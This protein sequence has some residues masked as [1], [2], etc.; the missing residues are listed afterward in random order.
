M[1]LTKHHGLGNDF[2][3]AVDQ[4]ALGDPA[5]SARRWCHR[6]TG[7]GADGLILA[8]TSPD[9]PAVMTLYN[10]D[11][12]RAEI[13]GN[14]LRCLVQALARR[15]G[16]AHWEGTV[17]TDAGLRRAWLEPTDRSDR[18]LVRVEMG[19]VVV[20]GRFGPSDVP[21]PL[22]ADHAMTVDVGNP[23]LVL[24]VADPEA[25]ALD[26]VGPALEQLVPGGVNVHFVM[27]TSDGA[28]LATHWERGAGVTQ[29]CGSGA[30][31]SAHA[32]HHWGAVGRDVTVLMPGGRARVILGS[33]ALLEG[34]A[35]FVAT[36]EV[37]GDS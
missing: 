4:I 31:A 34:A 24:H 7:V 17:Q 21:I 8:E 10:A 26:Q 28:L 1:Q 32:A 3:I 5:G 13:S 22:V 20:G 35:T 2:L 12:S 37:D 18:A 15:N 9:G 19:E 16:S 29:A 33:P 23:H 25:I 14:G 27:P 11:G 30:V 36:I 6:T